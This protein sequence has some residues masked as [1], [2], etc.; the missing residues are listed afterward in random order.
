[1][2]TIE[3]IPDR[4]RT[5]FTYYGI[6]PNAVLQLREYAQGERDFGDGEAFTS[7]HVRGL[8]NDSGKF[9]YTR[10]QA[11]GIVKSAYT[12]GWHVNYEK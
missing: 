10:E 5:Q 4:K 6:T 11:Q 2:S 8:C 7:L 9:K 3:F 12:E 1:M